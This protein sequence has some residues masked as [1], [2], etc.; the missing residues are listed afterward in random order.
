MKIRGKSSL[1]LFSFSSSGRLH[2]LRRRRRPTA[3]SRGAS[4][5]AP[6]HSFSFLFGILAA[7]ALLL[8]RS[9][10]RT[11]REEGRNTK[12]SCRER[13]ISHPRR[14]LELH[15]DSNVITKARFCDFGKIS[16]E[17]QRIIESSCSCYLYPLVCT[18]TLVPINSTR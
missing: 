7:I 17:I 6:R 8:E 14:R 13:G 3:F 2:S 12:S 18:L 11:R 16:T 9:T 4:S 5:H 1:H 10:E 15:C